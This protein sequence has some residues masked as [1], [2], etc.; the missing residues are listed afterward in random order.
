MLVH[1]QGCREATSI[2]KDLGVVVH[3]VMFRNL[4]LSSQYAK[5]V[6]R[7]AAL[8]NF[9]EDFIETCGGFQ[10]AF[11]ESPMFEFFCSWKNFLD[12]AKNEA[13][14]AQA[15]ISGGSDMQL[16][17]AYDNI[18]FGVSAVEGQ[19]PTVQGRMGL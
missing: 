17:N 15:A 12:E 9:L 3:R 11:V 8:G 18:R 4:V 10:K 14:S 16:I 1:P 7:D 6:L 19:L 5:Y 13:R 2:V